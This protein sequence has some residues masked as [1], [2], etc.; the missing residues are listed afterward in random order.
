MKNSLV[1]ISEEE[2]ANCFKETGVFKNLTGNNVVMAQRKFKDPFKF[3]CQSK[4]VITYNELPFISDS[5][6]GMRRRLLVVPFELDLENNPKKVNTNINSLLAS[7]LSGIFNRALV[8]Y[9]RL[10]RQEGFTASKSVEN[11]VKELIESSNTF[12]LWYSERIDLEKSLLFRKIEDASSQTRVKIADLY[13]DYQ[14]YMDDSGERHSMG[15]R[16][17]TQELKNSGVTL[18]VQKI[19]GKSARVAVGLSLCNTRNVENVAF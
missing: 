7:E 9:K 19:K 13:T 12:Y 10:Q 18:S 3:L 17:F 4:L 14:C 16:K 5:S 8:G 15:R 2:P 6:T 11:S 1:N